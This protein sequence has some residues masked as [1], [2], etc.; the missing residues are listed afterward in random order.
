MEYIFFKSDGN[1]ICDNW[2]T[3]IPLPNEMIKEP[4]STYLTETIRKNKLDIPN[5]M[6]IAS[7]EIPL[8][9]FYFHK[10]FVLT[11]F[12]TREEHKIVLVARKKL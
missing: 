11:Y 6:K 1:V 9:K 12:L 2:L 5:E 10:E 8:V 4:Y 3:I 7:K